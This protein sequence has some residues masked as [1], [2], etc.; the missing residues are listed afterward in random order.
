MPKRLHERFPERALRKPSIQ[1]RFNERLP[2]RLHERFPERAQKAG[3]VLSSIGSL[4]YNA[5]WP[6][7]KAGWVP[8][9]LEHYEFWLLGTGR[10]LTAARKSVGHKRKW[11]HITGRCVM[12]GRDGCLLRH[13]GS[14]WW[15][16]RQQHF[17][18]PRKMWNRRC[19]FTGT[20]IGCFTWFVIVLPFQFERNHSRGSSHGHTRITRMAYKKPFYV[21]MMTDAFQQW[22][23]LERRAGVTLFK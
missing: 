6:T 21:K 13:G 18:L 19:A 3:G 22:S 9:I 20:G 15:D 8:A 12:C 7:R 23:D 1:K 5:S 2:K 11:S 14:R 16:S 4:T 17:L 10:L